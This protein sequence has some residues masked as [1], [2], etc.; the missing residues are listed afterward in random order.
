MNA[1]QRRLSAYRDELKG[2]AILMVVFFH[3]RDMG[4]PIWLS[5]KV[6]SIGYGGVDVFFFLSGYGLYHSLARDNDLKRYF[7]RRAK[8]ILPA[9]LPICAAWLIVMIP[10]LG[11]GPIQSVCTISGNL[12]MLGYLGTS[13]RMISWYMS[14]LALS[15]LFA[16]LIFAF[17]QGAEHPARRTLMLMTIA[18]GA[19]L[20]FISSKQYVA[21]SRFPVFILGMGFAMP[22]KK[23]SRVPIALLGWLA[24]LVGFN[25]L[26]IC[27]KYLSVT[28]SEFGMYWHPFVLIAPSVCM[29]LGWFFEKTSAIRRV[30]SPLRY[31]GQASFEIFLLN[32]W[33]ET[34][35]GQGFAIFAGKEAR[36]FWSLVSVALGCAYHAG[37]AELSKRRAARSAE[38]A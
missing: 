5:E 37:I 16:P 27:K 13:P 33:M 30:F 20:S 18:F 29:G 9:Y 4:L 3:I 19:G 25:T 26:Q 15:L 12:C 17:L 32:V 38:R 34:L 2:F 36:V 1:V 35:M 22:Q 6:Q 10:M 21:I 24:F 23:E 7:L 8:R 28:L 14:G 31:C 11:I